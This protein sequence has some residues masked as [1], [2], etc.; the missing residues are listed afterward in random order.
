MSGTL[1]PAPSSHTCSPL[2]VKLRLELGLGIAYSSMYP[3]GESKVEKMLLR[4]ASV[5]FANSM[6]ENKLDVFGSGV[7]KAS[8]QGAAQLL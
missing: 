1:P 6:C 8:L 7:G 4:I 3:P 2:S 5:D